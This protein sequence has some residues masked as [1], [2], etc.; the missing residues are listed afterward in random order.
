MI[1]VNLARRQSPDTG[2]QSDR[3]GLS[4][5]IHRDQLPKLV[6]CVCRHKFI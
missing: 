3:D 1:Q 4:G 5:R 6:F 2:R